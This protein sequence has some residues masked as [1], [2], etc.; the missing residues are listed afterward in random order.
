LFCPPP[1]P[2]KLSLKFLGVF[3]LPSAVRTEPPPAVGLPFQI[4]FSAN[5]IYGRLVFS[6]SSRA[7]VFFYLDSP[8]F[9]PSITP[10]GAVF[11]CAICTFHVFGLDLCPFKFA[12]RRVYLVWF[13]FFLPY[14]FREIESVSYMR[15]GISSAGFLYSARIFS[16]S[17]FLFHAGRRA[18]VSD[19]F[20]VI[21]PLW[22]FPPT[23]Q[24][25]LFSPSL[26]ICF[27]KRISFVPP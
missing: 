3:S 2:P 20:N 19:P 17:G 13:F 23:F 16:L 21:S 24:S 8:E 26:V 7:L 18:V 5:L 11:F 27:L 22:G 25:L 9:L 14:S 1:P 10:I 6:P 15:T 12:G 4:A